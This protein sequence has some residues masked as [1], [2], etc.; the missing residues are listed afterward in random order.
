MLP[1]LIW[2]VILSCLSYGATSLVRTAVFTAASCAG[3]LTQNTEGVFTI[4]C[5]ETGCSGTC[6]EHAV[7]SGPGPYM[8]SWCACDGSDT[9]PDCCHL[10]IVYDTQGNILYGGADGECNPREGCPD[11]VCTAVQTGPSGGPFV[12]TAKCVD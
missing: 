5:R 9:E 3:E 7:V 12:W 2:A 8:H 11:G 4:D 1:V 10:I 6:T